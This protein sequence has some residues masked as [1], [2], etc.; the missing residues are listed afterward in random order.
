VA[1]RGAAAVPALLAALAAFPLPAQAD[2][3]HWME[4]ESTKYHIMH[5]LKQIG[6]AAAAA[7]PLLEEIAVDWEAYRDTRWQA[8]QA[9]KAIR[10]AE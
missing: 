10:P 6:P 9:L 4:D 2:T 8:E 1:E 5:A 7:V 3:G